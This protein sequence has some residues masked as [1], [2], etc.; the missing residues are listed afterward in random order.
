MIKKEI[1][2]KTKRVSCTGEKVQ[3]TEKLDGSNLCIFK[4]KRR[5]IYSSKENYFIC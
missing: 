3:I 4:K 1:Y 2:P 5:T